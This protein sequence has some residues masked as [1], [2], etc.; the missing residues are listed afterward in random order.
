MFKNMAQHHGGGCMMIVRRTDDHGV[1]FVGSG[2]L[3][4]SKGYILTCAH[5][6]NLT[7]KLSVIPPQPLQQFNQM[8][9]DRV[10][11]IDVS[12]A[13]FDTENDVA[14][15]KIINPPPLSVPANIFGDE[16]KVLVGSTVGYLGF[17]F[18]QSGLHTLKVSQSI[19]S[20]KMISKSGTKQFQLDAMVHEGN[21]G[22]PLIDLASNQI[23]G[24]IS[25]RFSPT[26][27]GGGIRIGNH[28]LGTESSISYATTIGYGL[29]LIRS[30]IADV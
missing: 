15:L 24:V 22:G 12:V 3:C 19:I 17:P 6:I 18:G 10:N 5:T 7:D 29:E 9:M 14:L 16:N 20:S 13:Q 1:E 27:N 26:G 23:I 11:V 4:H 2:F 8:T 28:A 25:G 30:E 21:S